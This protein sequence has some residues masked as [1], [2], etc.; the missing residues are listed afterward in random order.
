M[1][2]DESQ[3]PNYALRLTEGLDDEPAAAEDASFEL[4]LNKALRAINA[5]Q[6]PLEETLPPVPSRKPKLG[7]WLTALDKLPPIRLPIGPAIPWR[8]GL[9]ALV[10]LV[11]AMGVMSRSAGAAG[12]VTKDRMTSDLLESFHEVATIALVFGSI[13]LAKPQD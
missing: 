9:P 13:D 1:P 6:S 10:V 5:A 12:F 7:T 4:S 11:L 8:L 3:T 2:E